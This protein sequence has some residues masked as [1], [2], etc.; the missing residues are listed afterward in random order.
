MKNKLFFLI[1]AMVANVSVMY[2]KT[3]Y[4][5]L[6]IERKVLFTMNK[7]EICTY[8][9]TRNLQKGVNNILS[10]IF[11]IDTVKNITTYV[12]N[13]E[14][15]CT[16]ICTDYNQYGDWGIDP[17]YKGAEE[18]PSKDSIVIVYRQS[19]G[20]YIRYGKEV[21]GPYSYVSSVGW[22]K[23]VFSYDYGTPDG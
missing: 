16:G 23:F 10:E 18:M 6:G 12:M 22:N 8:V 15:I 17:A 11:V 14:R 3:D 2:A 19:D 20:N 13:G 21:Y 5:A 4:A 9:D 1:L 7:N